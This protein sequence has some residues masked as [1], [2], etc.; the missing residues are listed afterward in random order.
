MQ[1]TKGGKVVDVVDSY[2]GFTMSLVNTVGDTIINAGAPVEVVSVRVGGSIPLGIGAASIKTGATV[3]ETL[4]ATSPIGTQRQ[5]FGA[6]ISN[7]TVN[8]ATAGDIVLV[9]WKAANV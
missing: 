2:S 6:V 9:F 1:V 5:Y 7:F 3:I 8:L 4:A